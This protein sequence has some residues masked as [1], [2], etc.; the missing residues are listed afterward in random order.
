V[1]DTIKKNGYLHNGMKDLLKSLRTTKTKHAETLI[2]SFFNE[3]SLCGPRIVDAPG[4]ED[5]MKLCELFVP[6]QHSM[7][8]F[9]NL[10]EQV[11]EKP[12]KIQESSSSYSLLQTLESSLRE[13]QL[14]SRHRIGKNTKMQ[15]IMQAKPGSKTP[16]AEQ[17]CNHKVTS[18]KWTS[19]NLVEK[20]SLFCKG[21][22]H[23]DLS[24]T[25]VKNIAIHYLKGDISSKYQS[26]MINLQRSLRYDIKD[27]SCPAA[28]LFTAKDISIQQVAMDTLGKEKEWVA[29]VNLNT[30]DKDGYLQSELPKC[31][32]KNY[33]ISTNVEVKSYIDS[34]N[35]CYGSRDYNECMNVPKCKDK[36]MPMND[37]RGRDFSRE[38]RL[39]GSDYT[40]E[41]RYVYKRRRRLF[42]EARGGC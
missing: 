7:T 3:V 38:I 34:T 21:S 8:Q 12:M 6:Y 37:T 16:K 36:L 33:L 4:A 41:D 13:R 23:L 25:A 35:C 24:N 31:N 22:N 20:K 5:K 17:Q 1:T 19:D 9:Y 29:V 28:P 39:V 40:I 2:D 10:L 14:N 27:T 15:Q 11:L 18:T 42:Q 32:I 30:Q 26:Y